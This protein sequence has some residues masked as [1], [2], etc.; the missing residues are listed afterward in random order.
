M[1]HFS[2]GSLKQIAINSQNYKKWI[3]IFDIYWYTACDLSALFT[4][5]FHVHLGPIHLFIVQHLTNVRPTS[6]VFVCQPIYRFFCL[7]MNKSSWRRE[8]PLEIAWK[9]SDLPPVLWQNNDVPRD[10]ANLFG[11]ATLR[12]TDTHF[13]RPARLTLPPVRS[14][15]T[16][17]TVIQLQMLMCKQITTKRNCAA[18]N[19]L[20][21][22][23]IL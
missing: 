10:A 11:G 14:F 15:I 12:P 1:L 22:W 3:C 9:K 17:I 20:M 21:W 7:Q 23:C 6:I 8:E 16:F 13:N 18:H 19:F 4:E 5:A 2:H